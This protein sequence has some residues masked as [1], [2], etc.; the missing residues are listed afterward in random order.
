MS[1]ATE[2]QRLDFLH[3]AT[4]CAEQLPRGHIPDL[5]RL[6]PASRSESLPIGTEGDAGNPPRMSFEGAIQHEIGPGNVRRFDQRINCGRQGEARSIR[7]FHRQLERFGFGAVDDKRWGSWTANFSVVTYR[8]WCISA[9]SCG[10]EL[11][12][13]SKKRIFRRPGWLFRW[14]LRS[15][16]RSFNAVGRVS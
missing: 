3:L 14:Q 6:I 1:I 8:R 4:D 10:R 12:R 15:R 11:R 2:G 9:N 13:R 16:V 7:R 5:N